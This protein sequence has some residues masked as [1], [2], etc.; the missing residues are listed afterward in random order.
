L[1][2]ALQAPETPERV[3]RHPVVEVLRRVWTQQF[4]FSDERVRWRSVDDM[5]PAAQ[6]I[7]SPYDVEAHVGKKR[8]TSWSGYK[9]H[10]TETCDDDQPRLIT[11]VLT[12]PATTNDC[13]VAGTIHAD[14]ARQDLL[15]AEHLLD[16]GYVEGALIASGRDTYGLD[17][18]GPAPS[19]PSWQ[20]KAQA[21][22]DVSCFSIDWDQQ[23]VTCPAGQTSVKWSHTHDW[24]A[25]PIIN[26]RF[27]ARACR[28]CAQHTQCTK[29]AGARH[30]TLRPRASHEALQAARQRQK[31]P[32]FRARYKRWAGIEGT[33]TQ[34]DRLCGLRR[35]R[36]VGLAKT[37]LQ[38]VFT[39]VALNLRRLFAWLEGDPLAR[40]RVAPFVKLM[41]AAT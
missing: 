29:S 23:R 32:E 40:T 35:S 10:F 2:Q 34:A 17:I 39:A 8:E 22:F 3:R 4:D 15:P 28:A 6:L 38:H 27:P 21:G 12:T 5:P 30:L 13:L 26:I 37:H 33:F 1:W 16:A 18:V 36:Y 25:K 41:P 7:N 11:H 14:L 31:T 24:H 20:A 9:V 19:S